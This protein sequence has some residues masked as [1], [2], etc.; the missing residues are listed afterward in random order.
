MSEFYSKGFTL[1]IF[2]DI[3]AK[4]KFR[5]FYVPEIE[6]DAQV[7]THTMN[8]GFVLKAAYARVRL[9]P[10]KARPVADSGGF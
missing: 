10:L 1:G 6:P 5:E 9:K 4:E 3:F 2:V 7:G 8:A